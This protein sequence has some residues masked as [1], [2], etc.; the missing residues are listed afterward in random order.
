MKLK[1]AVEIRS[2]YTRRRVS[3]NVPV[4]SYPVIQIG[5]L[6]DDG[7]LDLGQRMTADLPQ[8]NPKYF[9]ARGDILFSSRGTRFVAAVFDADLDQAIVGTQIYVLRPCTDR[10]LPAFLAWYM[11]R[12]AIRRYF[13]GHAAGTF[14]KMVHR[15]VLADTPMVMPSLADQAAVLELERSFRC[16]R[17]IYDQLQSRHEQWA[18]GIYSRFLDQQAS[19][20]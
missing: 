7:R 14:V 15:D 13:A 4:F 1:D 11:N 12:P 17:D 6:G 20:G 10:L 2:G 3:G 16:V 8:V 5:N 9:L 18:E 19:G